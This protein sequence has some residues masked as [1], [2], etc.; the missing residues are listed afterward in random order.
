[1][2]SKSR[3]GKKVS[4]VGTGGDTGRRESEFNTF[5]NDSNHSDSDSA[6]SAELVEI[7]AKQNQQQKDNSDPASLSSDD[8]ADSK[9][10]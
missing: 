10:K 6:D 7:A 2:R 9:R 4:G 1:M 8:G 3:R 5:V